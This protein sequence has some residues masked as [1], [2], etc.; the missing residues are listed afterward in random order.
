MSP[1]YGSCLHRLHTH[2]RWCRRRVQPKSRYLAISRTDRRPFV[3]VWLKGVRFVYFN[4]LD[5]RGLY[6]R[7][8]LSL[9][10]LRE[11][12]DSVPS[13]IA[14]S[15]HQQLERSYR[16][17]SGGVHPGDYGQVIF[18]GSHE[19]ERSSRLSGTGHFIALSPW[20]WDGPTLVQPTLRV[21]NVD[22]IPIALTFT[23]ILYSN[24]MS[25][26][27]FINLKR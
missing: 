16:D 18:A 5:N 9:T 21:V 17:F 12:P 10:R 2:S 25:I 27:L 20:G 15:V 4:G 3:A 13:S 24:Q 22:F 26:M 6:P 8:L 23:E 14:K 19:C 11:F 1:L 7:Y